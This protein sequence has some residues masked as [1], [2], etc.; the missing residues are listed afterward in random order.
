MRYHIMFSKELVLPNGE[1]VSIKDVSLHEPVHEYDVGTREKLGLRRNNENDNE[2]LEDFMS[3]HFV[4]IMETGESVY[5][6]TE[7]KSEK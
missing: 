6:G 3:E 2:C 1:V 7:R 4:V 5:K